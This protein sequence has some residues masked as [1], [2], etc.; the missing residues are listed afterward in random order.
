MQPLVSI[1]IPTFNRAH[2]IEETLL[3]VQVQTYTRWECIIV[4]DGS[5]DDT[6]EVVT[7]F[8][9]ADQRFKI[10]E[11]PEHRPKGANACRNYGFEH[12]NGEF[13]NWLDSDDL[14]SPDKLASQVAVLC[15][16]RGKLQV[17]TCK[18]NKFKETTEGITPRAQ[19][20]YKNYNS[21][22]AL[23]K[24]FDG[25]ASFFPPL[26]YLISRDIVAQSQP[27]D[28]DLIINQDGE[29]FTRILIVALKVVH[30]SDGMCFYRVP[31]S[32][33][34]SSFSSLAKQEAA[35]GSWQLIENHLLKVT[36]DISY[37]YVANAKEYLFS[38]ISNR[39]I[40]KKHPV[41]FKKQLSVT[42][43]LKSYLN[44]VQ[45]RINKL[46]KSR[47]SNG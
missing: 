3:S 1:I 42:H 23:L 40:I 22:L 37:D 8:A 32:N 46:N 20:T 41:F 6:V 15:E 5:D 35:I 27:W 33:N 47:G 21:G 36:P 26:C 45:K 34:T 2:C 9:K 25:D 10:L 16:E 14:F 19:H 4:D 24:S 11:R 44:N 28:E 18:W 39:A 29:F 43:K 13:I 17:A 38:K 31:T 30:A 7:A 12:S